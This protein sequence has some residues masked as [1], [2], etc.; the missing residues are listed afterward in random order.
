MSEARAC[1]SNRKKR[2]LHCSR[3]R[4]RRTKGCLSTPLQPA[5]YSAAR[6]H[7][8]RIPFGAETPTSAHTQRPASS[9]TTLSPKAP[10]G[11]GKA[12]LG[13]LT[14]GLG[15]VELDLLGV[16]EDE[17]RGGVDVKAIE[18]VRW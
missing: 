13:R 14:E 7:I 12:G 16:L 17:G 11:R 8:S 15:L 4:N 2:P 3:A 5:N 6:S 9:A 1:C 10:P 18:D